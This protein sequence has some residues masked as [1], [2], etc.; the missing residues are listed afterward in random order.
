[1]TKPEAVPD[2][3]SKQMGHDGNRQDKSTP[4]TAP[5][6]DSPRLAK[7]KMTPREYGNSQYFNSDHRFR[8]V[9]VFGGVALLAL[10]IRLALPP[11]GTHLGGAGFEDFVAFIAAYGSLPV[12]LFGLAAIRYSKDALCDIGVNQAIAEVVEDSAHKKLEAIRRDPRVRGQISTLESEHLPDNPSHPQPA[13]LRLFQRVCREAADRRFESTINLL[14]PYLR[15]S[16]EHVLRLENVQKNALRAG[17]LCHFVGLVIVIN[18]V[19]GMLHKSAQQTVV[20]PP[21]TIEAPND[22]ASSSSGVVSLAAINPILNGLR[23]AFGASVGGLTVSLFAAMLLSDVRKRQFAYFRKLDEAVSTMLSLATNSLNND[24]L[25]NSLSSMSERL[26][27]QTK[28]VKEGI[29]QVATAIGGQ[30]KTIA[31]GLKEL[32]AGKTKLDGFL[33]GVSDSH[34]EFLKRLNTYYDVGTMSTLVDGAEKR[35]FQGMANSSAVLSKSITSSSSTLNSVEA[36]LSVVRQAVSS[37]RE[38]TNLYLGKSVVRVL[39]WAIA[40][41]AIVSLTNLVLYLVK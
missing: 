16:M 19:P 4:Q 3:G 17:I 27:E 39:P 22:L 25:L 35:L 10:F 21:S 1:V 37:I 2:S 36:D 23:L 12:A 14:E 26:K 8:R 38:T 13:A 15:E 6:V 9:A 7:A 29:D 18:A 28:V 41:L 34:E 24:E 5:V 20:P 30:A 11:S 33:K 40:V 31:E 32:N